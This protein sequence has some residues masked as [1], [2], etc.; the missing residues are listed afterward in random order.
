L[1]FLYSPGEAHA[2]FVSPNL[3]VS[4]A[5]N[6]DLAF[7]GQIVLDKQEKYTSPVQGFF[8][9]LKLSF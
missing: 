9:R 6:W 1:S 2:T 3:N 5:Q 8:L 4:I 7:F